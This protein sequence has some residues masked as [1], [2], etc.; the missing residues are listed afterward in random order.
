MVLRAPHGM[1]DAPCQNCAR[2]LSRAWQR[3]RPRHAPLGRRTPADFVARKRRRLNPVGQS[4][5]FIQLFFSPGLVSLTAPGWGLNV[6]FEREV[7]IRRTH[8]RASRRPQPS[9]SPR[10]FNQLRDRDR[11]RPQ[12]TERHPFGTGVW[13]QVYRCTQNRRRRGGSR[14]PIG[15]MLGPVLA[16]LWRVANADP[17]AVRLVAGIGLLV[18]FATALSVAR[19]SELSRV[20]SVR[21][22][23]NVGR[24]RGC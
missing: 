6:T 13:R 21:G 7:P 15:S 9:S 11:L 20:P 16:G 2:M 12:R 23:I 19:R 3:I 5:H 24:R 4:I 8:Q 14:G 18:A 10:T 17:D 1:I 22:Q